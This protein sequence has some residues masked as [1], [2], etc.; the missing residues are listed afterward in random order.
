MGKARKRKV[1][2]GFFDERVTTKKAK[3]WI[4]TAFLSTM[5]VI[6]CLTL[7]IVVLAQLEDMRPSYDTVSYFCR[8][9]NMSSIKGMMI[10]NSERTDGAW[11][12]CLDIT[13]EEHSYRINLTEYHRVKE[14]ALCPQYALC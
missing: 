11:F 7:F 12:N 14:E 2:K 6:T 10:A 9:K 8:G 4:S 5:I 1:E 13:G 3:E